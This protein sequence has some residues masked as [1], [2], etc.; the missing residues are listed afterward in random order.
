M[1]VFD[2]KAKFKK[3]RAARES[4]GADTNSGLYA[5]KRGESGKII[6]LG[7]DGNA[8]ARLQSLGITA[9]KT[10]TVLAYSL[11]RSSVLISCGAVRVGIRAALARRVEVEKCA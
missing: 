10:V 6:K 2:L 8:A 4:S 1:G 5:L 7:A 3:K 11:F 9:G